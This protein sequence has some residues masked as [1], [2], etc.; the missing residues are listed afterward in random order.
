MFFAFLVVICWQ[1][2]AANELCVDA[3]STNSTYMGYSY[4]SC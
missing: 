1:H 3:G 4:T 2:A